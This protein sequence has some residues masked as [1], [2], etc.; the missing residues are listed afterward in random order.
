MRTRVL[1]WSIDAAAHLQWE[2]SMGDVVNEPLL[3]LEKLNRGLVN[4]Y[5]RNPL[6]SPDRF[7]HATA[8]WRDAQQQLPAH[9][10]L[11]P[12]LEILDY[13]DAVLQVSAAVI[14]SYGGADPVAEPHRLAQ[15]INRIFAEEGVGYR[16]VEGR[17]VRTDDEVIHKQAVEST[18]RVLPSGS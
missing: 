15:G 1:Q 4:A 3:T 17:I 7:P 9:V 5:G 16:V 12:D 10:D 13:V 6:V 14:S 2:T 11:C 8:Y 18:I